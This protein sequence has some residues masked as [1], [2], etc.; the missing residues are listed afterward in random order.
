MDEY[1]TPRSVLESLVPYIPGG[2]IWEPFYGDGRSGT[3]LRE[4]GFEVIHEDRDF[5]T[6]DAG[7]IIVSNPPFSKT[8]RILERLFELGKPFMLLMPASR[9]STRYFRDLFGDCIDILVPSRISF[10]RGGGVVG[11]ANFECYWYCYKCNLESL[12]IYL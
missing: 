10:E 1:M 8:K 9:L 12:I 6:Y 3:Y 2:V 11:R 7:D 4:L 5:F